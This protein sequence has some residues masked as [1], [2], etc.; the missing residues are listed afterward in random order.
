[1][2]TRLGLL[3]GALPGVAVPVGV[4]VGLLVDV[5]VLVGELVGHAGAFAESVYVNW[6]PEDTADSS[7]PTTIRTSTTL[8]PAH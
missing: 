5:D 1:V 2:A 3:D 8:C 7:F 4:A 6:S